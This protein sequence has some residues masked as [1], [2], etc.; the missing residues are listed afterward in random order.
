MFLWEAQNRQNLDRIIKYKHHGL[1]LVSL[2]IIYLLAN[3]IK[4]AFDFYIFN[5]ESGEYLLY[6]QLQVKGG[7][8][9]FDHHFSSIYLKQQLLLLV[10]IRKY[11]N[12]QDSQ[13]H[14]DLLNI[15]NVFLNNQLILIQDKQSEHLLM[16]DN[17]Q[18]LLMI[19]QMKQE[20][21]SPKREY[22]K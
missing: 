5:S 22:E 15:W 1:E 10:K 3:S 2:L 20:K 12:L 6:K 13:I 8:S 14:F 18:L 17:A 11:L 7:Q 4:N 9:S 16:M 19:T 21:E